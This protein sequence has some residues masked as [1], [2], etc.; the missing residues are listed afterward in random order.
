MDSFTTP[1]SGFSQKRPSTIVPLSDSDRALL[2]GNKVRSNKG[3]LLAALGFAFIFAYRFIF[4]QLSTEAGIAL[5]VVAVIG[6]I[7]FWYLFRSRI[8]KALERGTKHTGR[9]RIV[10]KFVY[11]GVDG[12]VSSTMFKLDWEF[13]KTHGKVYVD[14]DLYTQLAE[15]DIVDIEVVS[16]TKFVLS[17]RKVAEAGL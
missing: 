9:A 8:N 11:G 10:Q 14:S 15:N 12:S 1:A 5:G 6:L 13:D 7:V 3:I 16:T 2:E 4:T 17:A